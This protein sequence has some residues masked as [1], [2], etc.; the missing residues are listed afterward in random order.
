VAAIVLAFLASRA[1][2]GPAELLSRTSFVRAIALLALIAG[3][4]ALL[5]AFK[6][7][8]RAAACFQAQPWSVDDAVAKLRAGEAAEG[9][10]EGQVSCEE[11]VTS[12]GG[13]VCAAYEAQLRMPTVDG[14]RGS[15]IN[16]ERAYTHVLQLRG[17]RLCAQVAFHPVSLVAPVQIRRCRVSQVSPFAPTEVL[18][19]GELAVEALS[20][21]RVL[22]MGETCRIVGKLEPGHNAGSYR[23]KGVAGQPPLIL[24]GEEV[25]VAG[26]RFFRS[27]LA[28]FAAAAVLC[29]A[30]AWMIHA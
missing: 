13:I 9:V 14:S 23:I 1:G 8:S 2:V 15:L 28:H 7:R 12:P 17:E 3:A 25:A 26:K 6:L 21:E 29:A 4:I 11:P 10:F 27:A 16:Q 5:L 22:R 24:V 20:Y 18:A 30:A 19:S